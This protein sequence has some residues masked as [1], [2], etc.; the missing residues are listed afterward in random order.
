MSGE[1]T[2]IGRPAAVISYILD[3][4][5]DA[6]KW[7]VPFLNYIY[8][9][10]FLSLHMLMLLIAAAFLFLLFGV[11][12]RKDTMVPPRLTNALEV[13]ILFIRDEVAV[14]A[15]GARDGRRLA[16]LFFSFFFFILTLNLMGLI[17][18]FAGATG[19]INVTAGLALCT[20]CFMVFGAIH[21]NGIKGF[22]H[23]FIP[24]G[25]P[26]PILIILVP[27]EMLG[28]LIKTTALTIRLFANMMAGS[29][30]LYAL[31]G[32]IVMFGLVALPSLLLALFIFLLKVLVA[33]LQA[34]IFT[35]LSAIFIGQTLHPEH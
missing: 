34:Y 12:Y 20:F 21:A 26:W 11:W 9:P 30:V 25:V 6:D 17:P 7:S 19:N 5:G 31:I 32:L 23:A 3:K 14:N 33:F 1:E 13:L 29:I 35:M 28:L 27:I 4:I 22:L 15:L 24:P 8:L 18:L 2:E 16:P 10:D